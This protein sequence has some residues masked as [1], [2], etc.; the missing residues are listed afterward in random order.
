MNTLEQVISEFEINLIDN[1]EKHLAYRNYPNECWE[2]LGPK[3][4]SGYGITRVNGHNEFVHRLY[5]ILMKGDIPEGL[6]IM[7]SC[8]NPCCCNPDHLTPG[9]HAENMQ[10]R[11]RKYRKQQLNK[12]N[13]DKAR[14]I[15]K[16]YKEGQTMKQIAEIYEVTTACIQLVVSNIT[17]QE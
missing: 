4:P 9:T 16:L 7:H 12:L 15:R 2:W 13:M 5:Y 14:E 10:D 3:A 17:W 1:I 11:T 8:D 6:E